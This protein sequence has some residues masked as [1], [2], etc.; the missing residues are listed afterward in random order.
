MDKRTNRCVED[1]MNSA[2]YAG[3]IV[4]RRVMTVLY[5]KYLLT[6]YEID[7]L[8]VIIKLCCYNLD[9]EIVGSK[10]REKCSKRFEAVLNPMLSKLVDRG[11]IFDRR[12][13]GSNKQAW[14]YISLTELGLEFHDLWKN[15][16]DTM[17]QTERDQ[18]VISVSDNTIARDIRLKI[19]S[20]RKKKENKGLPPT[21]NE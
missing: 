4:H 10:I 18:L 11:F 15:T 7:L 19:E 13:D 20:R 1:F 21:D 9:T 14:H 8:L 5:K 12:K 3:F 16:L 2:Y 17:I 6:G